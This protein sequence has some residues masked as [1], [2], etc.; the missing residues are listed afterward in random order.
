MQEVLGFRSAASAAYTAVGDTDPQVPGAADASPVTPGC[1]RRPRW[2]LLWGALA[3]CGVFLTLA[4][5]DA[6]ASGAAETDAPK[7]TCAGSLQAK[8]DNAVPGATVDLAGGCIYRESV[9]I[10]KPLTLQG[11][12]A[13]E[14]RGSD[15]WEDW[16]KS[17][18]SW[19]SQEPVPELFYPPEYRCEASSQRCRWP[20]QVFVDGNPLAQVASTPKAGQFALDADRR[21]VLPDDP[22]GHTV[23]VTVRE[24]WVVGK[25]RDV[26]VEGITMKHAAHNGLWN[27]GF[28]GWT[29]ERTDLSHA[30]GINLV[31]SIGGSLLA[32]DNHLH[33]AGQ[34][35]MASNEADVEIVGNRIHNNNTEGFD[36]GWAAGGMKIAQPRTAVISDNEIYDNEEIGIWTDIVNADQTSVE[37]ARNRIYNN[38]RQGI[39]VEITKNFSVHDNL[40]WENGWGTGDAYSGAGIAVAGSRDGTVNDN[41]LAWNASGIAVVQQDR[42]GADEQ[43][44][45]VTRDV[46]LNRNKI[47]QDEIP[48]SSEHAAILWNANRYA[49]AGG[50]PSLEDP[51]VNNGGANDAFWFDEP[52]GE[53]YRF[54][55]D[56]K[57]DTL[58]EYNST[59]AE[60]GGRYLSDAEKVALLRENAMPAAP[61]DHPQAQAGEGGWLIAGLSRLV[62]WLGQVLA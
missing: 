55:W 1:R 23:E 44:Y 10:D 56:D 14:I 28:P 40:L 35:G 42:R 39:R 3:V 52:E 6:G 29:V 58:A 26:T 50:A 46:R 15:V 59:P 11:S 34:L 38:P 33:H 25:S 60:S 41:V 21:V 62:D 17:G 13:G 48:G 8:I 61:K 53:T 31:L 24:E 43:A 12:G 49:I 9:V 32:R 27:A 22:E 20:E 4:A 36:P 57:Y 7:P 18:P 2:W 19:V 30:H 51:A 37:I 16:N 45:D 47:V 54:K 5:G